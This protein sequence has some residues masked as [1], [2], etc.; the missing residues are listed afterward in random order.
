MPTIELLAV[1]ERLKSRL[2][3]AEKVLRF[4]IEAFDPGPHKGLHYGKAI[5]SRT[6]QA[7]DGHDC[8]CRVGQFLIRARAALPNKEE[9]DA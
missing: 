5:H 6:C 2:A 7:I 9:D 3:T 1:V 4:G 8:D